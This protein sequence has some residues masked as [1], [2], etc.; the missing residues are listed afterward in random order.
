VEFEVQTSTEFDDGFEAKLCDVR[1]THSVRQSAL[2][3]VA[4]LDLLSNLMFPRRLNANAPRWNFE[5]H[6]LTRGFHTFVFDVQRVIIK[7][8]PS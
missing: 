5:T 7:H 8:R 6:D 4:V 3:C 2:V 1:A